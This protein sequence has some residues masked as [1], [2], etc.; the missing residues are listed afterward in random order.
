MAPVP[1]PSGTS[2]L[3]VQTAGNKLPRKLRK[4]GKKN[5]SS[6]GTRMSQERGRGQHYQRLLRQPRGM[7]TTEMFP[8]PLAKSRSW[9][10]SES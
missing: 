6:Y 2:I 8:L 1:K 10:T 9:V 5:E 4:N 3:N 7:L